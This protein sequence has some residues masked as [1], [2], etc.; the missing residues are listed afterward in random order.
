M[1][2][3]KYLYFN[4]PPQNIPSHDSLL[5]IFQYTI[6]LANANRSANYDNNEE[7]IV[8]LETTISFYPSLTSPLW[9]QVKATYDDTGSP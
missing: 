3:G 8:A 5:I 9:D 6:S 7:V 2:Q 4:P 1:Q